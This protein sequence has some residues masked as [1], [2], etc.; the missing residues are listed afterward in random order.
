MAPEPVDL[1]VAHGLV[2]TMDDERRMIANGAVA[3]VD[4]AIAAVGK[5][6]ELVAGYRA[7]ETIDATDKLVLPGL[8]DGHNHPV[9]FLSKGFIDDMK[10]PERW[11]DR[12][13]PYEIG[14]S[15]AEAELAATGTF[16]E[17]IRHGT[18]CFADPGTFQPDAIARAVGRVGIRGI[19]A[20]LTSDV[21][22][23]TAPP[24]YTADTD[25]AVATA[26]AVID[27]WHGAHGGRLRAWFSLVRTAHVTDT[28][29]RR[30]KERADAL[31]VGVHAHLA[32]TPGEVAAT[33]EVHG[34]GPV[35][36]YRRLGVLGANAYLVHMGWIEDDDIDVLRAHDVSVCHCPSASMFGGFGCVTHGKFPELVE[37]G[38]RVVLG[39]DACAVSRFLD[40]VRVMYLAACGHKDAK[41][42]PTVIGAHKALEMATVDAA[43]ALLW[44]GAGGI[45]SVEVG[46]RADLVVVDTD[47]IGWHPNPLCNPIGNLIYSNTGEAVRT[48]VIDGRVVMRDRVFTM[49][50]EG[51]YR[52]DAATASSAILGRI[53]ATPR[54]AWPVV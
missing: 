54:A 35:E 53:D 5:T 15:D 4:G 52:Q 8:I 43:R 26:E 45:G 36:R 41:I 47:G 38:V 18:T 32:T 49:I 19:I 48:V 23:A 21:E 27:K 42:D 13:W 33:K 50:D 46:K 12:V 16:L 51:A 25:T 22:D 10:F 31:G 40:M 37:A 9:H 17:M 11:R 24:N 1:L 39:T 3:V 14:L 6:D 20:R 7:K 2:V 29:C 34:F 30:V 44:D 28:L